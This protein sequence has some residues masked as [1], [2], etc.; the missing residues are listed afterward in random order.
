MAT[1][2]AIAG[3]QGARGNE[4]DVYGA[5][6]TFRA[7]HAGYVLRGRKSNVRG[8][9]EGFS[10][11]HALKPTAL[12]HLAGCTVPIGADLPRATAGVAFA[13]R[14]FVAAAWPAALG[15]ST[16]DCDSI[17][18]DCGIWAAAWLVAV[19]GRERCV[20]RCEGDCV[21]FGRISGCDA[22]R[23]WRCCVS[24]DYL[25]YRGPAQHRHVGW[26]AATFACF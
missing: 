22:F 12:P 11:S 17:G 7:R 8:F 20:G 9:I 24:A 3:C 19:Y 5:S 1:A 6:H 15:G 2:A 18:G 16:I 25:H 10:Q 13:V 4:L 26:G 21:W 23:V 14:L